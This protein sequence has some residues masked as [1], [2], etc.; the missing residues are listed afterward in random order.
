M[1]K[2]LKFPNSLYTLVPSAR[3]KAEQQTSCRSHLS[4][5]PVQPIHT[6]S[7]HSLTYSKSLSFRSHSLSLKA[8]LPKT[9]ICIPEYGWK[10]ISPFVQRCVLCIH[11][12]HM[13]RLQYTHI[14]IYKVSHPKTQLISLAR[15]FEAIES[16][17]IELRHS[18]YC[19]K[20]L[21]Y[22]HWLFVCFTKHRL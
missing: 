16:K 2:T 6:H 7:S 11:G 5:T 14:Y 9:R 1:Q 20:T 22:W 17:E 18:L 8:I 13:L 19:A 4:P 10:R 12:V 3:Q 15:T 21:K